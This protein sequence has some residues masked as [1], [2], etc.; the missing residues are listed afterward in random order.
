MARVAGP[1][2]PSCPS[3]S[4]GSTDP[5]AKMALRGLWGEMSLKNGPRH[6]GD[7]GDKGKGCRST[8]WR[9]F[10]G[11]QLSKTTFVDIED[12]TSDGKKKEKKK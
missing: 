12:K 3:F 9:P 2:A 4:S 5:L 10:G 1:S 11:S 8:D 7:A 6:G